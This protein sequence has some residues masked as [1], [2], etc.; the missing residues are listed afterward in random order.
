MSKVVDLVLSSGGMAYPIHVGF[1]KAVEERGFEIGRIWGVSAGALIGGLYASGKTTAEIEEIV[2]EEDP[3]DYVDLS[4][5]SLLHLYQTG[6]LSNGAKLK[7]LLLDFTNEKTLEECPYLYILATDLSA[8]AYSVIHHS[9]HPKLTVAEAIQ[10]SAA[11]PWVFS[12]VQHP[13]KDTMW[14]DGGLTKSFPIDIASEQLYQHPI[15]GCLVEPQD[16]AVTEPPSFW[17]WPTLIINSLMSGNITESIEDT[18]FCHITKP[19]LTVRMSKNISVT[20]LST[21]RKQRKEMINNSFTKTLEV[22]G[23]DLTY[24]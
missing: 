8:K 5:W 3:T 23:P 24:I 10:A 6:Y 1:I 21:T 15:I 14:A 7:Q 22:L 20:N 9:K 4:Y 18:T 12:P 16:T 13:T 11:L 17:Q 19:V 2:L